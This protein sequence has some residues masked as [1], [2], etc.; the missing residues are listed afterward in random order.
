MTTTKDA[1]RRRRTRSN[2]AEPTTMTTTMTTTTNSALSLY[3]RKHDVVEIW[4]VKQNKWNHSVERE[5]DRSLSCDFAKGS[6]DD[7]VGWRLVVVVVGKKSRKDRWSVCA[8]FRMADGPGYIDVG[9]SSRS[10]LS[11]HRFPSSRNSASS[12]HKPWKIELGLH[13]PRRVWFS[14]SFFFLCFF[15]SYFSHPFHSF[16]S[17]ILSPLALASR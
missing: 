1:R 16:Y 9:V 6:T 7:T 2:A 8:G 10:A 13:T 3:D 15:F 11:T 14:V 4:S 17:R 12:A 5:D